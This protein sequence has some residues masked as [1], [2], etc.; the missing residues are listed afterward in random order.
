[1][2]MKKIVV[3][4]MLF[5]TL[6]FSDQAFGAEYK[7][8]SGDSLWKISTKYDVPINELQEL[9]QLTSNYI[10]PGQKLRLDNK[11]M[12]KSYP[13]QSGDSLFII[14]NKFGTT[15]DQLLAHNSI[16]DANS[17]YIGQTIQIPVVKAVPDNI[18]T[19]QTGITNH[20][21]K[22]GEFFYK[23]A[24]NYG[25]NMDM[26]I[27]FNPQ[28]KDPALVQVGDILT[29]PNKDLIILSK[30]IFLESQGE[31]I[32][33]QIAVGNVIMNRV[34]D[35]RFPNTVK[36]VVYETGQFTPVSNGDMDVTIPGNRSI[37]ATLRAYSGESIVG[38]AIFFYAPAK[39]SDSFVTSREIVTIIGGH[40]F[41]R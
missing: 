5:G 3:S 41:A 32:E 31:S 14:A 2:K 38:D 34:K 22:A 40:N 36:E 15:I 16:I 17:L 11:P 4:G 29:I 6:L 39:T 20:T 24:Q 30:I 33:G 12:L 9:N 37:E 26:L 27:A 35:P 19:D 7:V 18:P 23:I 8:Q 1:M 10:Y 21:V 28:I 13:V 25:L